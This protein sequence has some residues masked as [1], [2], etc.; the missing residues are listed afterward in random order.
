[1]AN[2]DSIISNLNDII[3]CTA[4]CCDTNSLLTDALA[5]LEMA[6]EDL[7]VCE[8]CGRW[9]Q[10]SR[11]NYSERDDAYYCGCC[12][13]SHSGNGKIQSYHAHKGGFNF[14]ALP[15]ELNPSYY[16]GFELELEVDNVYDVPESVL[17]EYSDIFM[18]EEDGSLSE[19]FEIISH[20][21]SK[22]YWENV[23]SRCLRGLLRDLKDSGVNKSSWDNGRCGLHIHWNKTEW[24]IEA[25]RNLIRFV[26]KY[27]EFIAMVSGREDFGY[28]ELGRLSDYDLKYCENYSRYLAVN[29]TR[30]TIELR[31]PRGT[32][33]VSKVEGTMLFCEALL[34]YCEAD[35]QL[36]ES[37]LGLE[38]FL[39]YL[40]SE[41]PKA[42]EFVSSRLRRH[43]R[44]VKE[45]KGI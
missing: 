28:C 25:Q 35:A 27:S 30:D 42:T 24:S 1:M 20:P 41:E 13:E 37:E 22:L 10:T 14:K 39:T 3:D 38:S 17:E 8:D 16:R 12:F 21:M 32:L 36:W 2:L 11:A 4:M 40:V 43:G 23:G 45:L 26:A 15:D 9:L 7:V 31:F 19:G 18:Y 6:Y 29:F 34:K 44:T 33:D 5:T